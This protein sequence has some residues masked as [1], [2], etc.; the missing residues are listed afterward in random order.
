MKENLQ[1]KNIWKNY[2]IK[3]SFDVD[4][5]IVKNFF[6]ELITNGI[7]KIHNPN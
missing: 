3:D 1:H 5:Y 4:K 7:E 2:S 6:F